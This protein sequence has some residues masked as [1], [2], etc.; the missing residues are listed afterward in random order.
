MELQSLVFNVETQ[1][2]K[3]AKDAIDALAKS[4]GNL[5][6]A[7]QDEA[8]SAIKAEKVK[9]A[10]LDTAKK[11][12]QLKQA[13][14]KA[15]KTK[16]KAVE[17]E[18]EATK[19]NVSVL[20]R[21]QTIL[22][23]MT[24]GFSKGQSSVL[25][26][27][28]ASGALG[29]ELKQLESV[30]QVQR[31]LMGSDPFDKSMSGL[32]ALKNQY[33][34]IREAIRQYNSDMDLTRNQTRELAR[35]KERIIE[36]M[37]LEGSSF[38]DIKN[39]I[40][41][42]NQIYTEQASKVNA[43]IKVEKDRERSARDTANA[44]RN[45]QAAEE[46]LFATTAH[47]ND[48]LSQ[49]ATLN[50]R[51]A[52][53][54]GSYERNLRIAGITGEQAAQKLQ[55]FKAAQ[56]LVAQA[57]AKRMQN[58]VARGVGV[59]MGDVAVSL[60][61]GMNPFLVMIQQGDQLRGLIQQAGTDTLQ[62][63][64]IM[65][66]AAGQIARSFK[67]VGIAV[68]TF[69]S[70]A[71]TSGG[72]AVYNGLT[73]P[74]IK[75][76]DIAKAGF[77]YLGKNKVNIIP[78]DFGPNITEGQLK[79]NKFN[80]SLREFG[81]ATKATATVVGSFAAVIAGTLAVAMYQSS[82]ANDALLIGLTTTGASLGM[83]AKEVAGFAEANNQYS[84][85][86]NELKKAIAGLASEG[87]KNKEV[88]KEITDAAQYFAHVTGQSL[89]DVLKGYAKLG[90]DPVKEL[91]E[92]GKASGYVTAET[93]L[94]V[95]QLIEA[96]KTSEAT[97]V[98]IKALA[99]AQVDMA[100]D[101]DVALSPMGQLYLDIKQQASEAWGA[102]TEFANSDV[103]VGGIRDINAAFLAL[104]SVIG[105]VAVAAPS[106]WKI[107]TFQGDSDKVREQMLA[108]LKLWDEV[109]TE[110]AN[111]ILNP[112]TDTASGVNTNLNREQNAAIE[113]SLALQKQYA[114]EFEKHQ[115]KLNEIAS[116]RDSI[117]KN[118]ANNEKVRIQESAKLNAIEE[119]ELT[120]YNESLSKETKK[121]SGVSK[122]ASQVQSYY[123]KTLEK[124][125]DLRIQ[126][127]KAE[128]DASKPVELTTK[129]YAALQDTLDDVGKDGVKT[130][131]KLKVAEKESILIAWEHAQAAELTA[132]RI[133]EQKKAIDELTKAQEGFNKAFIDRN[134]EIEA[135]SKEYDYQL[136]ILFRTDAE[137]KEITKQYKLQSKEASLTAKYDK[138]RYEANIAY[139]KA[140]GTELD[141][142]TRSKV[143]AEYD[144]YLH[145]L[146]MQQ[147]VEL[148]QAQR[149]ANLG[150]IQEFNEEFKRAR[151]EIS[152][153]MYEA[154]TGKGKDAANRL[155]SY[156]ED[157][158]KRKFILPRIEAFVDVVMNAVM[159]G[160]GLGSLLGGSSGKGT[161]NGASLGGM[162][163]PSGGGDFLYNAMTSNI[164][165]SL[166]FS[167]VVQVPG[168]VDA[169]LTSFLDTGNEA[170]LE[171]A[172]GLEGGVTQ[173]TDFGQAVSDFAGYL[174]AVFNL[175]QG[176]YG[177]AAGAAIGN[178]VLPGIGGF[179][180]STLG[181]FL[182]DAFGDSGAPKVDI[183]SYGTQTGKTVGMG[184]RSFEQ[185]NY[186]KY[187]SEHIRGVYSDEF[188]KTLSAINTQ[189]KSF[190]YLGGHVNVKGKSSNQ[191]IATALGENNQSIYNRS[192][193]KGQGVEAFQQVIQE[194]TPR[195]QAAIMIDALRSVND[196]YKLIV[197]SMTTTSEDLTS[198]VQNLDAN[199]IQALIGS[200]SGAVQT[201]DFINESI[202]EISANIYI[203][204]LDMAGGF[205]KLQG[206]VNTYYAEFYSQTE[207]LEK[208][209]ESL[210][211]QFKEAGITMPRTKEQFRGIVESLDLTTT[212][213]Q[214]TFVTMMRLS[215]SFAQVTSAVED[216]NKAIADNIA[217]NNKAIVDQAISE[218]EDAYSMLVRSVKAQKKAI[219][220]D[221]KAQVDA[222][223]KTI[224]ANDDL[225][226]KQSEF[227]SSLKRM[228]DAI[229]NA[230]K[231]LRKIVDPVATML[232]ARN[233]INESITVASS[234][235]QVDPNM[236]ADAISVVLSDSTSQYITDVDYK[237]VQA[238]QAN[239]L[240][241]LGTVL[242]TQ[243]STEER[244]LK[245]IKDSNYLLK[246]QIKSVYEVRD[247]NIAKLDEMLLNYRE[248]I[249]SLK[250]IDNSVL[251]VRDAVAKLESAIANISIVMSPV[252]SSGSMGGAGA[253]GPMV[254]GGAVTNTPGV[255]SDVQSIYTGML[256]RDADAEGAAF[257]SSSGLTGSALIDAMREAAI[258]NGEI[259]RYEV[260]A[261]RIPNDQLAMIHK[262]EA[263]IPAKFNPWAG[264][265]LPVDN[266]ELAEAI[267]ELRNELNMLR[268]EARAT[269]TNTAKMAKQLDRTSGEQ[270]TLKV[271]IVTP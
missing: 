246:E 103:V 93:I 160:S 174:P 189:Y 194:E 230:V 202:S 39:A 120:R 31:K 22:D 84:T 259:P 135:A 49:N 261:N 132:L 242:G 64:T 100:N 237:R 3:D 166:G 240:E 97:E 17:E 89:D 12:L 222:I 50:E 67:D 234:G 232:D 90:K 173:L 102:V 196:D 211:N 144:K 15:S 52:L 180:G 171:A 107:L 264:G 91:T 87:F 113:K 56:E 239:K 147:N 68:G 110:R 129:A 123:N 141:P 159:N 80:D 247:Q 131:D 122:E 168:A 136:S 258:V 157:V 118:F 229:S 21:Q 116:L 269:A 114:T 4:M 203:N 248:Q 134:T 36:K 219:E 98:A 20:E 96:G 213:G 251:S 206:G 185:N 218:A 7:Q 267:V 34:E 137:V 45:V 72:K 33:G 69:I 14:E 209:Y 61:S 138:L 188:L 243:L 265:A 153:A 154:L 184:Q 235:G 63:R 55:K 41:D 51:A 82:K 62:L 86:A 23:Y 111:R 13:E 126:A 270:D 212:H 73:Q 71:I 42:Y 208:A 65:N 142:A 156:V 176:K 124:F 19:K 150:T 162:N 99:K 231:N 149:D 182:D 85:S 27:A 170:F 250:G 121:S 183:N 178:F 193:D 257:W 32:I 77:D 177:S 26:Y 18:T 254:G 10:Q 161:A 94:L 105:N 260:G 79:L 216:H 179:I 255:R 204:I 9:Q 207:K 108:D 112:S 130:W 148:T 24:Q 152:E 252:S 190:A 163:I 57:E 109:V 143:Q 169:Y 226:A 214:E 146:R 198:V 58:Y 266:S 6:A 30:L 46:R 115:L 35:D 241:E 92:L 76:F 233:F 140:L 197:G 224:S 238:I 54:L 215:G 228:I 245:A 200:L 175:A 165:Q 133:K 25:A 119:A 29:D 225:I 191:I 37:K 220:D 155:R 181:G 187:T 271:Q 158:L 172:K 139:Q 117:N 221:A 44:I 125:R 128:S 210:S 70:G 2:L 263:I 104:A 66:D 195:I 59:Q 268:Y 236:L 164:G 223:N 28:K 81:V 16:T 8:A 48:G 186:P 1:K 75:L 47:L 256:G 5:N 192:Y 227:T 205:E 101:I 53:A 74:F 244:M 83:S 199:A 40:R 167:K 253:G 151:G 249:D 11:E 145:D 60:A 262:N 217:D 88:L 106:L 95:D 78:V 38:T 43:L 127:T 201:F